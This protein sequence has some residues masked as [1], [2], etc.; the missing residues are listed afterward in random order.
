MTQGAGD[1]ESKSSRFFLSLSERVD[2]ADA[3]YLLEQWI[4]MALAGHWMAMKKL[5]GAYDASREEGFAEPP[6]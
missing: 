1:P 6:A 3:E 5:L 2:P 4:E